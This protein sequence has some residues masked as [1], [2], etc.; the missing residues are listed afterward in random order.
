MPLPNP[1]DP[2]P[3]FSAATYTGETVR[4]SDLK[5]KWVHLWFY[6]VADTPG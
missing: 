6:P 5:G 1:G 2:A 4:L 3:D